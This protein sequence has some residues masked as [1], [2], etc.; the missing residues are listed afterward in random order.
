MGGVLQRGS[1]LANSVKGWLRGLLTRLRPSLKNLAL[2]VHYSLW[3]PEPE[4]ADFA[5]AE[6]AGRFDQGHCKFAERMY[7]TSLKRIETIEAK[8]AAALLRVAFLLPITVGLL[9]YTLSG[10]APGSASRTTL[11]FIGSGAALFSAVAFLQAFRLTG[12]KGTQQL[13]LAA[14]VNPKLNAVRDYTSADDFR[15]RGL[16]FCALAND[17]IGSHW[18]TAARI[19]WRNVII[20]MLLLVGAGGVL[21]NAALTSEPATKPTSL[22]TVVDQLR[23]LNSTIE[24]LSRD[25]VGGQS[26]TMELVRLE[27]QLDDC[28]AANS[29]ILHRPRL[30]RP[31]VCSVRQRA[32]EVALERRPRRTVEE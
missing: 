1:T 26:R 15:T 4:S 12:I 3:V 25:A 8:A 13:H 6:I 30:V 21:L 2:H 27:L 7:D 24:K 23:T 9:A 22:A 5:V 20:S 19:V 31:M 28:V 32:A 29:A 16:L 11:L 17:A 18:A 14:I 10:T